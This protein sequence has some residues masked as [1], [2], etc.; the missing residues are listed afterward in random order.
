MTFREI[1]K[2]LPSNSW[3]PGWM[4]WWKTCA[5][6]KSY[7][8]FAGFYALGASL[9]RKTF[10]ED[11]Y[12]VLWPMINLLL[13]GPSGI[14]KSTVARLAFNLTKG[15]PEGT[16][17]ML[18]SGS[19]T[20]ESL[21]KDLM[22]HPHAILYASEL[23]NFFNRQKY[24]D[25]MIPYITDCLDYNDTVERR[26]KSEGTLIVQ[27]PAVTVIGGS[28]VEWL[29]EQLPDSAMT[30]GFL[31]RFLILNEEHKSQR[32]PLPGH[33]MGRTTKAALERERVDVTTKFHRLLEWV[34]PKMV[35]ESY[36]TADVFT[37]WDATRSSP[38]GFLAPFISRG[39]EFVIRLGMISAIACGRP[40][41]LPED[42]ALG[43]HLYEYCLGKL[44]AV[45]VPF[46]LKGKLLKAVLEMVEKTPLTLKQI[47]K[48]MRNSVTAQETT[49]LVNS[50]LESGDLVKTE[51][52]KYRRP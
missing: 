7:I 22:G 48:A 35:F 16:I 32:N 17:P 28:T 52:N 11:D 8:L 24:N 10:F 27:K 15:L 29:Q 44:Q 46:T 14:G 3:L 1:L 38:T 51:E 30:G 9:G 49:L 23:A 37:Y 2:T 21:H 13:I 4:R 34:P 47:Q 18:V 31:A 43:I 45:V 39:G 41:I 26:I 36:E 19:A 5:A 33:S 40:H 42:I 20:M 6:S 25:A 12:R 50:H